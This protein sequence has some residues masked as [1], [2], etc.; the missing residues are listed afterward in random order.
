MAFAFQDMLRRKSAMDNFDIRRAAQK[1]KRPLSYQVE[2]QKAEC[3]LVELFD[4]KDGWKIV[5]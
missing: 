3:T 5:D 4:E 2:F 1:E